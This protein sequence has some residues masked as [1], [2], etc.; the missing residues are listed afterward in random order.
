[1]RAAEHSPAVKAKTPRYGEFSPKR[2]R[3]SPSSPPESSMSPAAV[4][5]LTMKSLV[6]RRSSFDREMKSSVSGMTRPAAFSPMSTLSTWENTAFF[7]AGRRLR[8]P[9]ASDSVA[10]EPEKAA[11][12]LEAPPAVRPVIL[13]FP[14]SRSIPRT[15]TRLISSISREGGKNAPFPQET[16]R[17]MAGR[18]RKS[19]FIAYKPPQAPA[20]APASFA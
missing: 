6:P 8:R 7:P 1:M 16:S 10:P 11:L 9:T 5:P 14:S 2:E 3:R 4:S 20:P 13:M 17:K 19:L 18:R 15:R 12:S